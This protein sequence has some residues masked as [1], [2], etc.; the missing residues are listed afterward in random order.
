MLRLTSNVGVG[1]GVGGDNC[2][3]ARANLSPSLPRNVIKYIQAQ[4]R[5]NVPTK[6]KYANTTR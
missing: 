4:Q 1:V 6:P 2:D 5:F 3:T